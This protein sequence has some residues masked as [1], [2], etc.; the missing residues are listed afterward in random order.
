MKGRTGKGKREMR[1]LEAE[2]EEQN[3][4]NVEQR[5]NAPRR[6]LEQERD[7]FPDRVFLLYLL[8]L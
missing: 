5:G 6:E 8:L 1:K 4:R 3:K 2:V 7:R